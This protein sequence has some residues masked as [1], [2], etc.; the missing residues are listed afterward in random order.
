MNKFFR[1]IEINAEF[2][3]DG[4]FW[5]KASVSLAYSE[6]TGRNFEPDETVMVVA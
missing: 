3:F 6:S 4:K 1:E 5:R 2:W